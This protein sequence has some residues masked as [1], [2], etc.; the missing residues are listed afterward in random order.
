MTGATEPRRTILA[1]DFGLRRVGVAVG[2]LPIGTSSPLSVVHS[3]RNEPDWQ[4][5][6]GHLTD[7]NPDRLIVGLPYNM[8]GSEQEMT[9]EAKH[10]A[11]QLEARFGLPVETVDER[12][13]SMEAADTLR[14]ERRSGQRSRRIAKG[15]IDKR[16]AQ[17][18]LQ[19][20]LNQRSSPVRQ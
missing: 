13:S 20:W 6:A 9:R 11:K 8:D 18:I 16:A 7:W 4:T 5:I 19:T 15:D 17:I 3:I 14:E 10:F 12:L 1:F 2:V